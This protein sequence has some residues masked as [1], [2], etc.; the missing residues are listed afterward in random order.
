M[1]ESNHFYHHENEQ[2]LSLQ[3]L[4]SMVRAAGGYLQPTDDLRPKALEATRVACQ[5]RRVSRR[6]GGMALFILLVG[7][8]GFPDFLFTSQRKL[9]A[10]EGSELHRRATRSV[11]ENGTE[12]HWALFEAYSDMRREHAARRRHAD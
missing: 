6:L 2:P 11:V 3:Q 5:Q 8:T 1:P 12:M 9:A 10:L 4:E 7:A